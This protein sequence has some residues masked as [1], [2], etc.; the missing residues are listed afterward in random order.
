MLKP[1]I[2]LLGSNLILILILF[3]LTQTV[4]LSA[5]TLNQEGKD[6]KTVAEKKD[7]KNDYSPNVV[8]V[9]LLYYTPET[10]FAFGIGGNLNYRLGLNKKI[11][12]PS[13]LWLIAVYT[14]NKQY[15]LSVKPEIY[16][17]NNDFILSAFLKHEKFPQKFFGIGNDL[18]PL[19]AG[20]PYTPLLTLFEISVKRRFWRNFYA[21]FHYETETVKVKSY[22]PGGLL[23]QGTIPGSRGGS[24]SGIGFS[25]TW[26]D[27]DNIYFPRHGTYLTLAT[28]SFGRLTGGDFLYDCFQLDGRA[29]FPFSDSHV[30]A[31]QIYLRFISGDPPFYRLSM[32]GGDSLLR[33]YYKGHYRDKN[34]IALQAEYRVPITR[35]IGVVGFTSAGKVGHDSRMFTPANLKI[36]IGTGIRYKFDLEEG[37][38][39][40]LDFAW[41]KNSYGM[42][43]T[44]RESF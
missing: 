18:P 19:V 27:R 42:Y 30:L 8:L 44:A 22:S 33:G 16:I 7:D 5:N 23:E 15:Q 21:G 41:G 32:L 11:I 3:F 14:Q 13:S 35:R 36:S 38:S 10:R 9:P 6:N 4:N 2:Y 25:L 43:F 37:A 40:R 39:L 31:L 28:D 20:E 24:S 29:Y 1:K 34:A 12:R 17:K 26:D